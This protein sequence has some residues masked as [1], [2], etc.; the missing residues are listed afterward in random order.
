MMVNEASIELELELE[1]ELE[2][3]EAPTPTRSKTEWNAG[4]ADCQNVDEPWNEECRRNERQNKPIVGAATRAIR[5]RAL[6]HSPGSSDLRSSAILLVSVCNMNVPRT[7]YVCAQCS[8][9][10]LRS[11]RRSS[12]RTVPLLNWQRRHNSHAVQSDRPYRVAIVGS[13]PAGFYAAYRLLG[14]VDNAVVDMYE[15]LPVPFG[16]V[17]YGVAPDHPEVKVCDRPTPVCVAL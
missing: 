8:A 15:K 11:L 1:L 16:L 6:R 7:R 13:G 17:R 10:A 14:K 12:G 9:Q 5:S 2:P 3:T 4:E